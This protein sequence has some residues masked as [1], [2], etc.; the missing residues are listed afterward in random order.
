MPMLTQRLSCLVVVV[1]ELSSML[2]YLPAKN[3]SKR[4]PD[5]ATNKKRTATAEKSEERQK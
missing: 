5:K 3:C 4:N 1:A 2:F